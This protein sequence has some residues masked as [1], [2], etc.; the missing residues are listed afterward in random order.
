MTS[1][2]SFEHFISK[3]PLYPNAAIL[4]FQ[5]VR[6]LQ[7]KGEVTKIDLLDGE[8]YRYEGY[9]IVCTTRSTN[10][11]RIMIPWLIDADVDLFW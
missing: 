10:M 4:A 11:P 2:G 8:R 3:Y 6:D 7:L 9:L 1:E 5:I